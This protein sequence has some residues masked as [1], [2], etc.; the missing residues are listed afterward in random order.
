MSG[1]CVS[2][3]E[4]DFCRSPRPGTR[5]PSRARFRLPAWAEHVRA[6]QIAPT[7]LYSTFARVFSRSQGSDHNHAAA[8]S[9]GAN[10]HARARPSSVLHPPLPPS[11]SCGGSQA[12]AFHSRRFLPPVKAA[13]S[14]RRRT[15]HAEWPRP[16]PSGSGSVTPSPFCSSEFAPHC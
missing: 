11:R 10:L 5:L 8:A 6:V 4:A 12:V 7:P 3:V 13:E 2:S 14:F 9:S 16:L 1:V 15:S